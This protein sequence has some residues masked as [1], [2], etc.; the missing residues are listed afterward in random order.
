MPPQTRRS[1]FPKVVI[2]RDTESEE[3]S[4]E[5]EAVEEEEE[6]EEANVVVPEE[7]IEAEASELKKKGKTPI[8]ITLKKVCKVYADPLFFFFKFMLFG[9]RNS[10]NFHPFFSQ[11]CKKTGHEAGFRGATYIDCPMKPCF[12]CKMPG[13]F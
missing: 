8:T 7:T 1:S 11:V 5:D 3:S 4:S 10:G 2:E 12:L 6:Q 9:V 13:N